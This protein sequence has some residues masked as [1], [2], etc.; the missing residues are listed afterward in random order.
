MQRF[1]QLPISRIIILEFPHQ[2]GDGFRVHQIVEHVLVE[3]AHVHCGEHIVGWTTVGTLPQIHRR[4]WQVSFD[5][6][7]RCGLD[8]YRETTGIVKLHI[9]HAIGIDK[10]NPAIVWIHR[11]DDAAV[12]AI[13]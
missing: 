4:E 10:R 2:R 5:Q 1:G 6:W 8:I 3:S 11:F 12:R 13:A 9:R 7:I